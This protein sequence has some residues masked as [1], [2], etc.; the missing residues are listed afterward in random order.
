MEMGL[1]LERLETPGK[2]EDLVGR[3]TVH[4]PRDKGE[5]KWD[6]ELREGRPGR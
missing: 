1:I 6:E 2:G 3:G 4:P 5:E